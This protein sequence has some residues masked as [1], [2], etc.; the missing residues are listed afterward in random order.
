MVMAKENRDNAGAHLP[1]DSL[2]AENDKMV[3][4]KL[5]GRLAELIVIATQQTQ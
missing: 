4:M 2:Q 1:G 5:Q 3:A